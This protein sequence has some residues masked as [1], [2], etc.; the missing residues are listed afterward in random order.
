[1]ILKRLNRSTAAISLF[2]SLLVITFIAVQTHARRRRWHLPPVFLNVQL[3]PHAPSDLQK[4]F[5]EKALATVVF[6][7][8][9]DKV[10]TPPRSFK[11]LETFPGTV[12]FPQQGLPLR[13]V[14][15]S[16]SSA[17]GGK[18][19][20]LRLFK[21]L[22]DAHRLKKD[23]GDLLI[24]LD[25]E[26]AKKIL[27]G[28]NLKILVPEDGT[29][30]FSLGSLTDVS[31][32]SPDKSALVKSGYRLPSGA[33][34]PFYPRACAYASARRLTDKDAFFSET[35]NAQREF[36]RRVLGIRRLS[37]ADLREHIYGFLLT[38]FLLVL[39][40]ISALHKS[41]SLKIRRWILFLRNALLVWLLMT[42]IKYQFP[43]S[44]FTRALWY[45][46]YVFLIGLPLSLFRMITSLDAPKIKR[47][48]FVNV[49]SAL[50]PCLLLLVFTNDFTHLVFRFDLSRNWSQDYTYG[51]GYVLIFLYGFLLLALSLFV[52][53]RKSLSSPRFL[54]ALPPFLTALGLVFY[55]AG[56]ALN[57]P[58]VR[59][60]VLTVNY[61]LCV[62][63]FLESVLRSGLV[64]TN[65]HYRVLFYLSPFPMWILKD[66]G[67]VFMSSLLAPPLKPSDSDAILLKAG[68]SFY[69][70]PDT[71][72]HSR[73]ITGGYAIWAE[74][75]TSLNTLNAL[76][77]D[78]LH[79][80]RSINT[81]LEKEGRIRK[82]QLSI[83]IRNTMLNSLENNIKSKI[84]RLI[85]A[86]KALPDAPDREKAFTQIT[87]LLCH[88]KRHCNL[89]FCLEEDTCFPACDLQ[90]YLDELS[91]IASYAGM[92]ALVRCDLSKELP[93]PQTLMLYDV[94][95]E[96]LAWSVL[97]P[98]A[99]VLGT[100]R[101]TSSALRFTL[102][103]SQAFDD[104][105]LPEAL[106][107]DIRSSRGMLSFSAPEDDPALTLM[108]P[109][110]E[111]RDLS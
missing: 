34:L 28:Q 86:S 81:L 44:V 10:Q 82:K 106:Q 92:N 104:F 54:S 100:L 37:S 69:K 62:I 19:A 78:E 25:C 38:M 3:S 42:L 72:L 29:L 97:K 105:S 85:N 108:L 36:A 83:E 4:R 102:L 31:E 47:S 80:L 21:T 5:E 57:I 89:F 90:V 23:H 18:Q 68:K 74:D 39:W 52:L 22:H 77:E 58:F 2:V 41:P 56:Y 75:M 71:L 67:T 20:A 91:D 45:G 12:S 103:S 43:D 50:F 70:D 107:K 15:A 6:A 63:L 111:R 51:P 98:H 59:E 99:T 87:I 60:S 46:Y 35:R 61:T 13:C 26:A 9:P 33:S 84:T 110:N 64:P 32:T 93:L 109:L 49:L 11:A 14:L 95:F 40:S 48:L 76:L 24:L 27:S 8:C 65:T 66:D 1:M 55:I 30:S 7:Y 16:A 17:L 94:Y 88:I 79:S 73:R 96:V 101:Q 53:I